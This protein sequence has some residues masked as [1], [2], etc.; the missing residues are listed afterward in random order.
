ME[1]SSELF[2]VM[3]VAGVSVW[4]M[5]NFLWPALDFIKS[6][7]EKFIFVVI[8]RIF[9]NIFKIFKKEK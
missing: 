7:I 4:V 1:Y 6:A 8:A 5:F 9:R 3:F 2:F